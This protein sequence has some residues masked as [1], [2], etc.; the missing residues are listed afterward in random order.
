MDFELSD[1]Q[2]AL[3]D[4]ARDLLDHHASPAR[5]RAVVDGDGGLRRRPVGGHGRPGLVARSPC[6]R[7]LGGLGLG[8]VEVAVLLE[9]VGAHVAP[10]PFLQQAVALDALAGRWPTA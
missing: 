8:L 1:D 9:E 3:R 2:Q 6:P 5:V 7:T 10:A 4:A